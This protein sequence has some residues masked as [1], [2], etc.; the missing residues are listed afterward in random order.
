VTLG[1]EL[2][3]DDLS[4]DPQVI[5]EYEADVMRHNKISAGVYLGSLMTMDVVRHKASQIR[6]PTLMQIAES[7]PV[8][9]SEP[10][11]SLFKKLGA[12]DKILKE[13]PDRMHEIYN[14]LGREE[15]FHDLVAFLKSHL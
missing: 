14:D 5:K 13:Y 12:S 7:D 1:N 11:R 6:I 9:G 15:V 3:Y 10:N 8:V 2:R 4:R